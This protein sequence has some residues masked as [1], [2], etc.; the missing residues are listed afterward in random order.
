VAKRKYPTVR[1]GRYQYPWPHILRDL[2]VDLHCSPWPDRGQ[3]WVV[4]GHPVPLEPPFKPFRPGPAPK[5]PADWDAKNEMVRQEPFPKATQVEFDDLVSLVITLPPDLEVNPLKTQE[6]LLSL[7]KVS[8]VCFEIFASPEN[9]AIRFV[10]HQDEWKAVSALV[11]ANFPGLQVNPYSVDLPM[12]GIHEE[13]EDLSWW[14]LLNAYEYGP[15][16]PFVFPLR[17]WKKDQGDIW[18]SLLAVFSDLQESEGAWLQVLFSRATHPWAETGQRWVNWKWN[19]DELSNDEL[20]LAKSKLQQPL[21]AAV[22]RTIGI[23]DLPERRDEIAMNLGIAF[24]QLE[25]PISNKLVSWHNTFYG[26]SSSHFWNVWNR[27]SQRCGALLSVEE[28][29][30]LVRLPSKEIQHPKLPRA[31][32][33]KTKR[34]PAIVEEIDKKNGV[35]LGLNF[36]EDISRPIILRP[37]QRV[38]HLHVIGASG[39]GKSTLLF[40][41]AI[42]DIAAGRGIGILDPH[43]DLV[44]EILGEIPEHR[45]S[46]VVLF[47]PSDNLNS[48]GLNVLSANSPEEKDLLASDLVAV[49]RRFSTSWGDQMNSVLANAI[50]AILESSQGGTLLELRRF[51]VDRLFRA[52]FLKTVKDPA[53]VHYWSKEYPL[54]PAKSVGPLLTRLDAFVRSKTIRHIMAQKESKIDFTKVMNEGKIFLAKLSQGLIGEENAYLLGSLLVSKFQQAAMSRQAMPESARRDYLLYI[55]E[56]HNFITPSLVSLLSGARKYRLGLILAHQEMRQLWKEDSGVGSA[57]LTNPYTRICFRLGDDDARKLAEGFSFFNAKDLQNLS[58]GEAICR[59][60]RADWDFNLK[61]VPRL[62]IPEQF[63]WDKSDLDDLQKRCGTVVGLV[64]KP[65]AGVLQNRREEIVAHSRDTYCRPRKEI[66]AEIVSKLVGQDI[67]DRSEVSIPEQARRKEIPPPVPAVLE[68]ARDSAVSSTRP[69][70]LAPKIQPAPTPPVKP[71]TAP[72]AEPAALGRGGKDHKYIQNMIKREAEAA[73]YRVTIEKQV[74][75]GSVDV[76]LEKAGEP[77]IACEVSITTK[78][79]WEIGN[80][81]KCLRAD[82]G[83]IFFIAAEIVTVKK[84]KTLAESRFTPAELARLSFR[85]ADEILAHLQTIAAQSVKGKNIVKGYEVTTDLVSLPEDEAFKRRKELL[86][87]FLASSL[88]RLKE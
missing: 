18:P 67:A 63:A 12:L 13:D 23:A 26:D 57:V 60:E 4:W 65:D 71:K 88:K 47:D 38:R 66:E 84:V 61:A 58:T 19:S 3:G 49:F 17:T 28:L 59:V 14:D 51:L 37:D 2:V 68:K 81:E 86:R 56:F 27:D 45:K 76:V 55:D 8:Q 16:R 7:S 36:H 40:N 70:I 15:D 33:G 31:I 5:P 78:P 85:T 41:L 73:G 83:Q 53:T 75:G 32:S 9:I 22:V 42:Q 50:Q 46:D 77:A 87:T 64:E 48:P 69:D 74:E 35:L 6:F 20:K 21:F 30:S 80:L 62:V 54:L 44:D 34:L 1:I 10:V 25:N 24:E 82:F 11:K 79:E 39:S 43:G 29:A 52:S 72:S